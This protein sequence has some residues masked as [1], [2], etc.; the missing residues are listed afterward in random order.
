M[1]QLSQVC[2]DTQT[3]LIQANVLASQVSS[4]FDDPHFPR[5][6]VW[7]KFSIP[8]ILKILGCFLFQLQ[9][10]I[11]ST[12]I[13]SKHSRVVVFPFI[14]ECTTF[15]LVL[16]SLQYRHHP[17]YEQPFLRYLIHLGSRCPGV[18][19][20]SQYGFEWDS[21]ANYLRHLL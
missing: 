20:N 18:C 13:L 11:V 1:M 9:L 14:I 10:W 4:W 7:N 2:K 17:L 19:F 16:T 12:G 5:P 15:Q 6:Y 3:C 8:P 21:Q